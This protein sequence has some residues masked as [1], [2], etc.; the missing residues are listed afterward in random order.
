MKKLLVVLVLV[1]AMTSGANAVL[2]LKLVDNGNETFGIKST[3][4]YAAMDDMYY[5][6]ITTAVPY[7]HGGAVLAAAPGYPNTWGTSVNDDAVTNGA[8][9][10]AGENGVW[11]YVGDAMGVPVAAGLY[12]DQIQGKYG[13]L[14]TLYMISADWTQVS[15][16]DRVTLIPEPATVMLLGLG[17]LLL[18]RRK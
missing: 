14:V 13:Q 12:I 7:P 15:V 5:C 3:T 11:G 9:L 18:R 4:N 1:L 10:P 16:L 17:G 8:P 6:A 2:T